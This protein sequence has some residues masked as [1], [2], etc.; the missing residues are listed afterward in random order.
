LDFTPAQYLYGGDPISV[1]LYGGLTVLLGPNGAGKTRSLKR[2]QEAT[3]KALDA[4]PPGR[5]TIVRFLAAG[6]SA[7][8]EHFRASILDPGANQYGQ[9]YIGHQ[10][11]IERRHGLES[12]TGDYLGLIHRP[13]LRIK[14]EARLQALFGKSLRLVWNQQGL[15]VQF[16]GEGDGYPANTEASGVVQLAALLAALHDDEVSGLCI[17]EPEISLHPQWQSFLLEE[18]KSVA[19]DPLSDSTKKLIVLS[20]HARDMVIFRQLSDI[21]NFVF[22]RSPDTPPIQIAPTDGILKSKILQKVFARVAPSQRDAF[23]AKAILLVEGPSDE[24]I[25]TS[26]ASRLDI[27]LGSASTQIA[28]VLGKD[29]LV[30]T[31]KLFK[32]VGKEVVIVA[33]LDALADNTDLVH[34]LSHI[35]AVSDKAATL[36]SGSV[37]ELDKSLRS[38]FADAV[39]KN[40][41]ELAPL[42]STHR[43]LAGNSPT[44][45]QRRAALATILSQD[46]SALPN[47]AWRQLR[48]RFDALLSVLVAGKCFFIR[49]G[50]IED[51]FSSV[52]PPQTR[53]PDAASMEAA[54]FLGRQKQELSL[55]YADILAALTCAAPANRV[56]ETM[57]VRS[58]LAGLVGAIFEQ[59]DATTTDNGLQ[60]LATAE[61][62]D[63]AAI[64]VLTNASNQGVK[65]LRVAFKS[66]LFSSPS[67]PGVIRIDKNLSEQVAALVP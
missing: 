3:K 28:A 58:K 48:Q 10:Q 38:D 12:L 33:D 56:N 27:S 15:V 35:K 51:C 13:D 6:R 4:A 9:A 49:K 24:I 42:A 53:K 11:H 23:F 43:Y 63:A 64:F 5:K 17:D 46:A 44:I 32:L 37:V 39:D 22:F 59:M 20:T 61:N 50:T 62:P 18:V 14:V 40:W 29:E 8:L 16:V 30:E 25:A 41:S 54:T 60:R 7:P 36:G 31:A 65:A 52:V 1:T 2:I 67:L 57:L 19:G 55:A 34:Y 45:D 21:S 66:P 26:L 47:D